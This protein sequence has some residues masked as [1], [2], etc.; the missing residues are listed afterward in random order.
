MT[1]V[2]ERI[3]G[4][5]R[6][7]KRPAASSA[8][9][10]LQ[11]TTAASSPHAPD[12]DEDAWEGDFWS[13][14]SPKTVA[15]QLRIDYVDANGTA[16]TR[17]VQVR[18]FGPYGGQTLILGRCLLRNESRTFRSDRI[19]ACI[20]EETGEV[21]T[22]VVAHLLGKYD[23]DPARL[24]ECLLTDHMDCLRV[25]L[26]IGKS[27]GQLRAPEREII[28]QTCIDLSGDTRLTDEAMKQML[29]D[30][31]TSSMQAFKLAVGRI[32]KENAAHGALLLRAAE[33]MVATQKA[34]HPA[35]AEALDYLRRRL[36]PM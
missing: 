20:D 16:T 13:I 17:S 18:E 23:A 31:P 7:R 28:R 34:V 24:I 26:H 12:E 4:W 11:S 33:D 1:S 30:V 21:V 36:A 14:A 29:R 9:E 32:A 8:H 22:D 5:I 19:Q 25:L 15:A 2:L 10:R 3:L 6:G 27:D 35:E